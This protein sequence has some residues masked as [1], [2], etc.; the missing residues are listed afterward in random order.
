MLFGEGR[1]VGNL[2][3]AGHVTLGDRGTALTVQGNYAQTAAGKLTVNVGHPSTDFAPSLLAVTG[4]VAFGGALEL[5]PLGVS[6]ETAL[7]G[8]E[9]DTVATYASATGSFTAASGLA[10]VPT[11]DT[12]SITVTG[13][14]GPNPGGSPADL[15]VAVK[16]KANAKPVVGGA[17]GKATVVVVNLA[18]GPAVGTVGLQLYVSADDQIDAGDALVATRDNVRVRLKSLKA[19]KLSLAFKYPDLATG[20]Y[21]LIARV[22]PSAAIADADPSDD[23]AATDNTI[24]I[25]R[26]SVDLGGVLSASFRKPLAAGHTERATVRLT[27]HGNTRFVGAVGLALTAGAGVPL[28]TALPVVKLKARPLDDDQAGV[29]PARRPRQRVGIH[30]PRDDRPDRRHRRV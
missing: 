11:V 13:Q 23:A 15:S 1:L 14:N 24:R 17:A 5:L 18:D 10:L 9:V 26:A 22:V 28:T 20:D 7:R 27:N 29:R 12:T 4:T 21:H 16:A 25:E 8:G 2:V 19:K 6:G 3:N 30:A